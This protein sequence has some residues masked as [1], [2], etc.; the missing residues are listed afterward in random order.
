MP[1]LKEIVDYV[2]AT[3]KAGT[4]SSSDFKIQQFGIAQ[5]VPV[6][7]ENQRSL[8]L[9]VSNYGD[10]TFV[11]IDPRFTMTTYHRCITKS[12]QSINTD[13]QFGDGNTQMTETNTMRMIVYADRSELKR[14]PEQIADIIVNGMPTILPNTFLTGKT[15]LSQVIILP[16]T[17]EMSSTTVWGNEFI[18]YD[19]GVSPQTCLISIEYTAIVNYDSTCIESCITC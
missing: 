8:P 17:V 12:Y 4:L 10:G 18:G 9:L 5:L 13:L 6:V 7:D 14:T 11:G 15:G 2:N 19:Y 3:L 1:F 16:V